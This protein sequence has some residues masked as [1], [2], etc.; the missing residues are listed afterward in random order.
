MQRRRTTPEH[1]AIRKKQR[2]R[3]V[4]SGDHPD[5]PRHES[6]SAVMN[7]YIGYDKTL[8][9]PMSRIPRGIVLLAGFALLAVAVL[10][11]AADAQLV[12]V[13]P[14]CLY[15][16]N[17]PGFT[18]MPAA[19]SGAWDGNDQ[20]QMTDVKNQIEADWGTGWT[21]AG[22]TNA[23]QNTGPF[24]VVPGT[25]SG[26]IKFHNPF[27][28]HF[29]L[30]LKA[31]NQFSMYRFDNVVALSEVKFSTLGTS[32]NKQGAPQELSHASMWT[33]QT[34]VVPEPSTVILLGTGLLGLGIVGYRRRR[35]D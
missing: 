23:G 31:S 35:E 34:N 19:C 24:S 3:G 26:T 30:I 29:I 5:D 27:T 9:S 10:P 13:D 28:G 7:C 16:P 12:R 6:C 20:N 21:Y 8:E 14:D 15:A 1:G 33:Q 22:K 18:P 4:S 32:L 2:F 17:Y 11:V 25:T